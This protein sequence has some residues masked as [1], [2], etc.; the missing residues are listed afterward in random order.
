MYYWGFQYFQKHVM[1]KYIIVEKEMLQNDLEA[2]FW[3]SCISGVAENI[4]RLKKKTKGLN[5]LH[6]LVAQGSWR[7]QD[8]F[9]RKRVSK[10]N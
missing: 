10:E 6:N 7:K 4:K 1:K 2:L 3:V 8:V 9:L 5:S